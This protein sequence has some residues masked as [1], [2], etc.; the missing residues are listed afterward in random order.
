MTPEL[1]RAIEKRVGKTIAE[2]NRATLDELHE[3]AER[4][5]GRKL[6]FKSRWPLVGRGSILRD[7]MLTHEVVER[8]LDEALK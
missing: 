4:K 5:L 1:S 6:T 3:D 2:I 7:R 8:L